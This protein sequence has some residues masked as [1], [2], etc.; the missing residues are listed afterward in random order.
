MATP[1]CRLRRQ[2]G[3]TLIELMVSLAIG[4]VVLGSLLVVYLGSRSAYRN[5]DSLARVQESGRFA[6]EFIAQDARM[7]GFMGCRSRNLFEDDQTLF[8]ITKDPEIP[9]RR[10]GDGV[11]GYED[12]DS[13]DDGKNVDV[14]GVD[15]DGQTKEQ[16]KSFYLRGD[17]LAFRFAIGEAVGISKTSEPD[18]ATVT[19]RGETNPPLKKGDLAVLGSCQRAMLFHVTNDPS[20][21]S[22]PGSVVLQHASSGAPGNYAKPRNAETVPAFTVGE[23]AELR[24]V[25]VAAYFVGRNA[26][27]RPG[28][29]RAAD[30]EAE[31]LIDNVENMDVLYGVDTSAEPDGI[32]DAYV[33]ADQLTADPAAPNSWSRV[34]SARISLLVVGPEEN[35]TA[36]RQ[37]YAF[38]ETGGVAGQDGDGVANT[39]QAPPDGRLRHVFTTTISLRNRVL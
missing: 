8:N 36:G 34:V 9:F 7:S 11:S 31:E 23:R 6:I 10:T 19:V 24:R 17:V 18:E 21:G 5:S 4:L 13:D 39:R 15:I 22:E 27:G 35:I 1:A 30:G 32:I 28:L 33:R 16:L 38:G 29:F 2:L 14:D 25:A 3:L 20:P 37:T 26:A 12:P